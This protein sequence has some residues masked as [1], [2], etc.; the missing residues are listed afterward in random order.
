MKV[1]AIIPAR[2]GSKGI[3]RKNLRRIAGKPLVVHSIQ[4]ALATPSV[5]RTVVSTDDNEI[6]SL[7]RNAGAEIVPRPADIA[8]D[9]ASSESALLHALDYLRET[10]KYEPDLVVFLQATSPLRR[11]DDIENAIQVLVRENADSLFSACEAHGLIWRVDKDGP[12]SFNYD[13]RNRPRRQDAPEE[14]KENGSI[15][16]FKPWVL[17]EHNNRLGG[18]IA[19]YRMPALDS[20][21]VDE[22]DDLAL[23]EYLMTARRRAHDASIL[24]DV[25]LLVFDFDG[26]MTDNRVW[27]D[28][29]GV[30][31]V[32]CH[33]GDGLGLDALREMPDLALLVLSKEPNPVVA[34][35]CRKLRIECLHGRDDKLSLLQDKARAL[36][37][38]PAQVAYV[39]ND[40]NDLECMSWVG[41]AMAVADAIPEV[42]QVA[43]WVTASPGGQGAVR[44]I[45]DRFLNARRG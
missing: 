16:V 14:V 35:R 3:P 6:A 10:D 44:E 15:Y 21:Q 33:R 25:K 40:R 34:A 36:G 30:E 43:H 41:V 1:L 45:A 38:G 37:L 5:Q 12:H 4:Q 28:E 23:F 24:R 7:A 32:A 8:G 27:V 39:G 26:V 9:R 29:N 17:R 13:Y 42:K 31:S 20:F 19:V 18:R 2:G 22:P 11:Q